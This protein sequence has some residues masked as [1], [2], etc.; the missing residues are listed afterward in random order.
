MTRYQYLTEKF[1]FYGNTIS[2]KFVIQVK[3]HCYTLESF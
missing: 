2:N 1:N 3:I